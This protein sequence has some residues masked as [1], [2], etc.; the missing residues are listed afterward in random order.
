MVAKKE[1]P[2]RPEDEG[3]KNPS[4]H[5]LNQRYRKEDAENNALLGGALNEARKAFNM[6]F[7]AGMGRRMQ[8]NLRP[9]GR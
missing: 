9:T 2:V 7:S 1:R 8:K 3:H 4:I 5:E 6:T